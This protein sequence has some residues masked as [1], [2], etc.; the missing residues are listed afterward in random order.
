MAAIKGDRSVHT[1]GKEDPG[2]ARFNDLFKLRNPN[3]GA[4]RDDLSRIREA[5]ETAHASQ[6]D[7]R[8]DDPKIIKRQKGSI[9]TVTGPANP[10]PA[11]TKSVEYYG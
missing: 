3:P 1:I 4:R 6:A 5:G 8:A 7:L 10:S 2:L 11:R 9:S